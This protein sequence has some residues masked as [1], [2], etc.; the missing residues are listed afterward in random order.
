LDINKLSINIKNIE[1]KNLDSNNL[2]NKEQN[3]KEEI[4]LNETKKLNN[5]INDFYNNL[6]IY[7]DSITYP[8]SKENF[9]KHENLNE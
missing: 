9:N 4:N 3:K 6:N 8:T 1:I 7:L 2:Q 5:W